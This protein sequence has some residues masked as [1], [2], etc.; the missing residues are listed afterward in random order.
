MVEVLHEELLEVG[1]ASVLVDLVV[2]DEEHHAD[3][4][5]ASHQ[6][7]VHQE[8]VAS[9]EV[10]VVAETIDDIRRRCIS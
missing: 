2:L 3:E 9:Q 5:E 4:A 7:E 1:E 10:V 8:L 6:A